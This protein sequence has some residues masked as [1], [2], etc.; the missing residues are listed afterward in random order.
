MKRKLLI[1]W[2]AF[3]PIFIAKNV[4]GTPATP[5][6]SIKNSGLVAL[7]RFVDTVK[8]GSGEFA[9]TVTTPAKDGPNSSGKERV[10]NSRGQLEFA[11]PNK[12][13]LSYGKPFEQVIASDGQTL[14]VHDVDLNQLTLRKMGNADALSSTP[15]ALIASGASWKTLQEQ[16]KFTE[17]AP[18]EATDGVVWVQAEP[19]SRDG[20]IQRMEIGLRADTLALSQVRMLDSLGQRTVL[21][22]SNWN[23]AA[24]AAAR[25]RVEPA[26]GTDVVRQ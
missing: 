6:K 9:Q 20:Q 10:R 7:E 15:A 18:P 3:A 12:F 13:R 11:R 22:F 17:M 5:S 19:K 4:H 26:A 24:P 25:F 8:H 2:L 21:R 23:T 1:A 14:A 16:F